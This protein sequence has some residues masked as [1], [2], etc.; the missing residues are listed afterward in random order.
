MEYHNVHIHLFQFYNWREASTLQKS[1][2]NLSYLQV[3]VAWKYLTAERRML[4]IADISLHW[5][6]LYHCLLFK[7]STNL[8]ERLNQ[9]TEKSFQFCWNSSSRQPVIL[10]MWTLL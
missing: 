5:S 4:A 10:L 8:G 1:K 3:S 2:S 6:V 7:A 9:F